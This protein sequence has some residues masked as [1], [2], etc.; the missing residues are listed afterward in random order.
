L[1]RSYI[2]ILEETVMHSFSDDS[3]ASVWLLQVV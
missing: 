2:R 3:N 1:A